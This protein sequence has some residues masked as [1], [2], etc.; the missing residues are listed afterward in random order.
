MWTYIHSLEDK[1]KNMGEELASV[2]KVEAELFAKV[3][4]F[5]RKESALSNEVALL[6]HQLGIRAEELPTQS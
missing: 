2:K 4:D 1:V 6:R 3:E 5:E